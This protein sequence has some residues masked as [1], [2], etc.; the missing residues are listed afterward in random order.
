MISSL[1]KHD[2][3]LLQGKCG[4]VHEAVLTRTLVKAAAP[5]CIGGDAPSRI[6]YTFTTGITEKAALAA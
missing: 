4:S 3:A 6:D 5:D 1:E 2:H